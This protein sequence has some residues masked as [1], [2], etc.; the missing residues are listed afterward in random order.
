MFNVHDFLGHWVTERFGKAFNKIGFGYTGCILND[1]DYNG[2]RAS[3]LKDDEVRGEWG[4]WGWTSIL[5]GT[6]RCLP[7][8]HGPEC[9]HE[10]MF[11]FSGYG[12]YG[13]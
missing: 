3:R 9:V 8:A 1:D 4:R 7:L 11:F 12:I 10:A 2:I 5:S 13:R 6:P